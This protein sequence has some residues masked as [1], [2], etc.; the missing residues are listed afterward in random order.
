MRPLDMSCQAWKV[1]AGGGHSR[2]ISPLKQGGW[3]RPVRWKYRN[4]HI[5]G[6]DSREGACPA[7]KIISRWKEKVPSGRQGNS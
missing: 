7:R 4:K 1:R 2:V 5:W 3:V 6:T